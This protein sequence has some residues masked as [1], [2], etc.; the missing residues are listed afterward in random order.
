MPFLIIFVIIPIIEISV[1]IM[2]REQIGVGTTLMLALLT[3]VL[4]GFII[5]Y[6]GLHLLKDIRQALDIGKIPLNEL[7]DGICLIAAGA[8]L[9]TPGFVTDTIGFLLLIPPVRRGLRHVIKKHTNWYS[10]AAE[11]GHRRPQDPSIIEGEV[12]EVE[13]EELDR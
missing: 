7:F 4:G 6:Q 10:E 2:V 12:I 3:A 5:K 8:T 11:Y 1:F 13:E 9:I